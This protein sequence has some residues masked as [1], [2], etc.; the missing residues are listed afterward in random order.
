L[1][2]GEGGVRIESV[3]ARFAPGERGR[4]SSSGE[5]ELGEADQDVDGKWFTVG[6]SRVSLCI[7]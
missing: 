2:D 6:A 3:V 1:V 4:I 5:V 7:S